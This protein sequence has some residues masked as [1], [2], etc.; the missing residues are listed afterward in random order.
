MTSVSYETMSLD[1]LRQYVLT[2]RENIQAFHV[3]I[4]RSKA[5]GRMIAID[6]SDP[7]WENNLTP[8]IRSR[9]A[10]DAGSN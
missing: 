10:D 3:Y 8:E 9:I 5:S 1:E 2:H 4:D 7:Q 6:P